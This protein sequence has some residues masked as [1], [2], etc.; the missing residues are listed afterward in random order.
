MPADS[1]CFGESEVDRIILASGSERRREILIRIGLSFTMAPQDIDESFIGN[2]P[3]EEAVR[4]AS[5]KLESL[6][7]RRL[8]PSSGAIMEKRYPDRL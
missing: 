7:S 6:L 3:G 1:S 5:G 4:L 8:I 2:N